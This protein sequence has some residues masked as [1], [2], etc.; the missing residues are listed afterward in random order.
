MEADA[1]LEPGGIEEEVSPEVQAE[2]EEEEA[3]E[4][5]EVEEERKTVLLVCG[6]ECVAYVCEV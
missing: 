3:E 4:E 1:E 6:A 2:A 5:E